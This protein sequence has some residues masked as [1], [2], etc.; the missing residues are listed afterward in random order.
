MIAEFN[1]DFM[2]EY[3]LFSIS[4]TLEAFEYVKEHME[5]IDEYDDFI[6]LYQNEEMVILDL[7]LLVPSLDILKKLSSEANEEY[8]SLK[9]EYNLTH[10]DALKKKLEETGKEEDAYQRLYLLR[11]K[12][13]GIELNP[14]EKLLFEIYYDNKNKNRHHN[15]KYKNRKFH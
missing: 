8:M 5:S 10:Q 7:I 15:K 6:S 11:K 1:T 14:G 13:L 9:Q 4:T 12:D 2:K 3:A